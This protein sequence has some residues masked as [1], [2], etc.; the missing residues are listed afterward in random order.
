MEN[1]LTID[2]IDGYTGA[3]EVS[4]AGNVRRSA[5]SYTRSDRWGNSAVLATKPARILSGEIGNSGYHMTNIYIGKKRCRYLTHRLVARAFV[6]GY[7]PHLSVNHINGIKTDNRASNL[8]WVTL[9]ENTAKQWEDGLVDL[10][11]DAHPGRKISSHQATEIRQRALA[12]ERSSVLARE[13]G[14]SASLIW[15]IRDGKRWA[16]V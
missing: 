3:I 5:M 8:E 4:D 9:S 1:W 14:V 11:G 16:S 10:R 12:G 13:F 7:A 6:A 2:W 15:R